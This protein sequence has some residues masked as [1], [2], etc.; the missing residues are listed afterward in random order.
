MK[1]EDEED[2]EYID[3][4]NITVDAPKEHKGKKPGLTLESLA[5]EEVKEVYEPPPTG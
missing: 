5:L 1:K 2:Y 3:M 4:N